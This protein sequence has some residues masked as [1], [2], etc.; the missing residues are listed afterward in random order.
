MSNTSNMKKFAVF[1]LDGTLIRWQL[2]HSIFDYLAREGS[3]DPELYKKVTSARMDWKRRTSDFDTYQGVMVR[4]FEQVLQGI[5]VTQFSRATQETFQEHKDQSYI[6]T[7][8]LVTSLKQLGYMLLAI[9]GSPAEAV[10]RIAEH[11]GF[12]DYVGAVFHQKDGKFT[13]KITTPAI[14]K[15][16]TLENLIK[17]H[18]VELAGSIAIG[19]TENDIQIL[20]IVDRPIAFNPS[21]KLFEYAQKSN[22]EIVVERKNVVYKFQP[23]GNQYVLNPEHNPRAGWRE[24]IEQDI[25][26]NG[27]LP[28]KDEYGDLMKESEAT[29]SDGLT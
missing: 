7:R 3:I 21:K 23:E 19:D 22:W 28:A 15:K 2:Y 8:E 4:V 27:P 9:S 1:D 5:P 20:E 18:G 6:Y 16:Q 11:Y 26:V 25:K 10:E 14:N 24:A 17:K 13:G 29:I 12:D